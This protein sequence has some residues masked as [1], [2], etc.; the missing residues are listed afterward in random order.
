MYSIN[1]INTYYSILTD[2]FSALWNLFIF[3]FQIPFVFSKFIFFRLNFNGQ[4]K[5]Y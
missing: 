3:F 4:I 2:D 1:N 5:L